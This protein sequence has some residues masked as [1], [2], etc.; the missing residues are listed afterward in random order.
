PIFDQ[1]N[2]GIHYELLSLGHHLKELVALFRG[3]E[4]HHVFNSG[5]VVPTAVE[6]DDLARR[7]EMPHVALDVHLRLLPVRRGGKGRHSKHA[8]AD[9][10]CN[11][12][13]SAALARAVA[14]LKHDDDP[15]A[16]M[17]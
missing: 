17:L 4:A 6:D 10:L 5:P 1:L 2:A 8:W 9:A 15:Q 14:T 7:G 11:S 13:D 12:T 3:T 16:F